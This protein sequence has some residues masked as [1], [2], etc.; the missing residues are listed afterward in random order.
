MT[1]K[2][3]THFSDLMPAAQGSSLALPDPSW[4]KA[5]DEQ[6]T[7]PEAPLHS[8]ADTAAAKATAAQNGGQADD[9]PHHLGHRD[10]LRT[11]FVEG[12]G[13]ALADY[14]LI[15]MLLFLGIPRK[16]T[17]PLAKDLIKHFKSYEA[18]LATDYDDLAAFKGMT[19]NAAVAL[20]LVQ[21]SAHR[22]LRASVMGEP[23][24]NSWAR[25]MDY[26]RATMAQEKREH[27]RILFLDRKNNLIADEVQ[28]SG[29]VDQ[30]PVYPREIVKRAIQLNA[31]ALILVHN[32]P[33]G[34]PS[35]SRADIDMTRQVVEAAKTLDIVVH[36]HIIVS[37]KGLTSLKNEGLMG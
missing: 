7:N 35:P 33:S 34:D 4:I 22:M 32:H 16:D 17:K 2:S 36:D 21:A 27:F 5:T 14:E 13:E 8:A 1:R 25:L 3:G 37:R 24:L 18:V 28:Q 15:E 12:G 20:K 6:T 31:T 29:T 10:R 19:K 11:R 26:L 9:K 23:V 30:T